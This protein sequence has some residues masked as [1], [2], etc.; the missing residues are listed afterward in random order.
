MNKIPETLKFKNIQDVKSYSLAWIKLTGTLADSQI[1]LVDK[2]HQKIWMYEM[3]H[4]AQDVTSKIKRIYERNKNKSW[5]NQCVVGVL[6]KIMMNEN[7]T[8]H[9]MDIFAHSDSAKE[10]ESMIGQIRTMQAELWLNICK[11]RI[12]WDTEEAIAEHFGNL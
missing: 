10:I 6:Y 7:D 4:P 1:Y 3:K 12:S 11:N 9:W 2:I 8:V 5:E